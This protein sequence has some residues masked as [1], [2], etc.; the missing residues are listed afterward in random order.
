MQR[1]SIRVPAIADAPNLHDKPGRGN[2]PD[3]TARADRGDSKVSQQLTAEQRTAGRLASIALLASF[4]L[5][6]VGFYGMYARLLVPGNAAATA[7][8]ILAD[9]P[10]F[11]LSV[12]LDVLYAAGLIVTAVAFYRLLTPIGHGI[13]ITAA[14]LRSAYA[15]M[16]LLIASHLLLA[17]RLFSEPFLPQ[18]PAPFLQGLGRLELVA[19]S[20][21]YYIGL[22]LWGL[23]SDLVAW[24]LLKSRYVPRSLAFGGIIA[25]TWATLSSAI[26]LVTP[27]FG[28]AINLYSIDTPL[29]VY[30]VVLASWILARGLRSGTAAQ[31]P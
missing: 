4:A 10:V 11:R 1:A 20:D 22:P 5:V 16:W 9:R 15:L 6:V 26:F 2:T 30:E 13:A 18:A 12:V 14:L 25:S 17:L 8:N 31:T 27:Q 7:A 19:A 21:D 24:L 23:A 29:A 28:K 3:M